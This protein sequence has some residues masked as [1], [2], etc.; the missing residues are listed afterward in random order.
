MKRGFTQIV[1]EKRYGM[2]NILARTNMKK[3][4]KRSLYLER[5]CIF[6]N[7]KVLAYIHIL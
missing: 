5:K 7:V 3:K 6:R 4:S 1:T 2:E